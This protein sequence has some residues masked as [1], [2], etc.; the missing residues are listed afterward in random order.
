[1]ET[2]PKQEQIL[3]LPPEVGWKWQTTGSSND[4]IRRVFGLTG[5]QFALPFFNCLGPALGI[6]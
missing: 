5:S 2:L 1:M 6:L 3:Q 4:L